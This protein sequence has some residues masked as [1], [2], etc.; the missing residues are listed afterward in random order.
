[1]KTFNLFATALFVAGSVMAA[2]NEEISS[3]A[4][5]LA[6]ADNYSWKT[7][8]EATGNSRFRPGPTE[9]KTEKDGYTV[10][11]ITRGDN[12]SHA[13]L[14]GSQG[15]L[16]MEDDW[17]SLSDAAKDDGNGP[18]RFFAMM[19]QNFKAPAAEVQSLAGKTKELK[20]ADNTYSGDLTEEG[21]K[22]LLTF[23]RGGNG[24]EVS[25]AKGS[26]KIW[27]KDGMVSKYQFTVQGHVEF[28][29]NG[30]DVNRTTTVEIKDV[31]TTKIE[32]PDDAKKKIS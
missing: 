14:K 7:T 3:A 19:L 27:L 5:K 16:K 30:R 8:V 26:V 13:V 6:A 22:S 9:G 32:V 28:N 18:V 1:M 15:A 10:L 31:G 29:G 11:A 4:K 2:D 24:P 12:T 25:E 20:M 21:A 17:Q 23:G